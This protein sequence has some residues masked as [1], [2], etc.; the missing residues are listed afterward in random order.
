MTV[1]RRALVRASFSDRIAG[2]SS[3]RTETVVGRGY[4]AGSVSGR[5]SNFNS[6]LDSTQSRR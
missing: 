1:M 6:R 3:P 5:H 2:P 4:R